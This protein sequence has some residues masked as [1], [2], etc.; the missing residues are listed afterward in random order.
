MSRTT[1]PLLSF[2]ASGQIA[3]TQV[4]ASWKGRAYARRYVIPANPNSTEQQKTRSAWTWLNDFYRLLPGAA[5]E[6]WDKAALSRQLMG[7]NLL[8]KQNVTDFRTATDLTGLIAVP[9]AGGGVAPGSMVITP[10]SGSLSCA[11]ASPSLPP[12]WTI[13]AAFAMA[14]LD[15]DPTTDDPSVITEGTDTSAPY[16]VVLSSLTAGQL[17]D[18]WGWFK[19]VKPDTSFAYSGQVVQTGTPS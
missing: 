18:V 8:L 14:M 19:Y 2:G 11:M 15:G 5:T 16:T 13:S 4:Y 6:A 9:S 7:R 1:A 10:G 12:G 3:K 17:Y